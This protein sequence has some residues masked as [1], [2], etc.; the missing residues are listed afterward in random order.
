MNGHL[1]EKFDIKTEAAAIKKGE[2]MSHKYPYVE[3]LKVRYDGQEEDW[4]DYEDF[5]FIKEWIKK[6]D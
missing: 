5:E 3:L 1:E 6:E 2:Q 4:R